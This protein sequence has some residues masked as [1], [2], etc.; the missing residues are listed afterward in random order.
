M[1]E[2]KSVDGNR[3][4]LIY[5]DKDGKECDKELASSIEVHEFDGKYE[6]SVN[7]LSLSKK[8]Y[9]YEVAEFIKQNKTEEK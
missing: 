8:P 9:L 6:K 1:I 2:S 5:L 7:W 3:I 4:D